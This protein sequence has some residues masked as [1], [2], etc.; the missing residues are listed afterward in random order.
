MGDSEEKRSSREPSGKP[1]KNYAIET[2]FPLP[3]SYENIH[4]ISAF[5]VLANP[6]LSKSCQN[7]KK[8]KICLY[9][10]KYYYFRL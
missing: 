2:V 7:E 6:T 8:E 1:A 4:P 3:F 9:I 10:I 5:N